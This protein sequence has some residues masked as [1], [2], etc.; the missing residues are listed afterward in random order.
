M[1]KIQL[2]NLTAQPYELDEYHQ[3][4]CARRN[5]CKCKIERVV[6]PNGKMVSKR[7]FRSF[8]ITAYGISEVVDAEVLFVPYV[9]RLVKTG[10]LKRIDLPE[11]QLPVKES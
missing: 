9:A 4:V 1:P 8:R 3:F 10:A 11:T 5:E 2:K 7:H 6:G